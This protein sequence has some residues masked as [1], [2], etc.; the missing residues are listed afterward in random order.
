[1]EPGTEADHICTVTNLPAGSCVPIN[2]KPQGCQAA[3]IVWSEYLQ[4]FVVTL[5]CGAEF[6][7][8][9][10]NDLITWS[11]PQLLDVKH[12]MPVNQSKE[13]RCAFLDRNVYLS[14]PLNFTS[15]LR[16]KRCHAC[17]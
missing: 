4:T 15:L 11:A 7:W 17:N 10:S 16:L 3:G 9:T 12:N 5:G 13:V 6:K 14:M 8:A 1:M 2:G